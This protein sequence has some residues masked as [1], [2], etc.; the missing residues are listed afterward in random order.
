MKD[1]ADDEPVRDKASG[2]RQLGFVLGGAVFGAL[3]GWLLFDGWILTLTTMIVFSV[4]AER[5]A[6][7]RAS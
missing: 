1:Q 2:A 3:A 5:V 7:A 4:L 6:H